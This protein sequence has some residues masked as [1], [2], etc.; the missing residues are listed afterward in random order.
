MKEQNNF[1][2]NLESTNLTLRTKFNFCSVI[3]SPGYEDF[4]G[5]QFNA[6]VISHSIDVAVRGLPG[7]QV[8]CL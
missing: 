3:W 7:R 6:L 4:R 8:T 5:T 2:R 1:T